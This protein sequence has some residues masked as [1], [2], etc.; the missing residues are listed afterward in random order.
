MEQEGA[1]STMR[2]KVDVTTDNCRIPVIQTKVWEVSMQDPEGDW[3]NN[4]DK[5]AE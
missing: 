4:S 1:V 2:K 5:K 3:S